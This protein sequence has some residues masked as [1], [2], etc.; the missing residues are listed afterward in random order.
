MNISDTVARL[1]DIRDLLGACSAKD[2]EA[3]TIAINT[4]AV[5][6]GLVEAAT[7][8][9]AK[10]D[11]QVGV[12]GIEWPRLVEA[13]RT[14]LAGCEGTENKALE[15]AQELH[16]ASVDRT[17]PGSDGWLPIE[18][19]PKDGTE[20]LVSVSHCLGDDEWE[21][22]Y[23]VDWQNDHYSWP[24]YRGRI[25]IPFPPMRW[26]PS[27]S[28]LQTGEDD[29]TMLEKMARAMFLREWRGIDPGPSEWACSG[30]YWINSA[31]AALETLLDPDEGML[32]A[33]C[34]VG[35]DTNSGEFSYDDATRVFQAAIRQALSSAE[36]TDS[37]GS[38][39]E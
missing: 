17:S 35:P 39:G 1:R 24:I 26:H 22:L 15:A 8:L 27:P 19:A 3:L 31:Q 34:E 25:D 18:S 12:A 2:A 28:I 7:E 6:G 32:N 5:H 14:A 11:D 29:M 16:P 13:L 9:L 33:A 23:R 30:P 20:V 37:E 4:L 38:L 36:Q 10:E 21:T